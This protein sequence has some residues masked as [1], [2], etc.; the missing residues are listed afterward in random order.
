MLQRES[1][2][3]LALIHER[4]LELEHGASDGS[5]VNDIKQIRYLAG[6]HLLLQAKLVA[7]LQPGGRGQRHA[8]RERTQ[9]AC[10]DHVDD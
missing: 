5:R 1:G 8:L 7:N 10:H 2:V 3:V 4:P 9:H 6:H